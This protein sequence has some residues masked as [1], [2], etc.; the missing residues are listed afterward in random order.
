MGAVLAGGRSRRMGRDKATVV[1][2]GVT[3]RERAIAALMTV[4]DR[5]VVV[6]GPGAEIVDGGDGPLVALVALLR[7]HPGQYLVVSATDQPQLTAAVLAPLLAAVTDTVDGDDVVAWQGQPLPMALGLGVL[8]RLQQLV[9]GGERRLRCAVT[10]WLPIVDADVEAGLIDVDT[11]EDLA[12][13]V[14][15]RRAPP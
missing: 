12:A 4:C 14:D 2:D 9:D 15:S 7:A 5:V 3:M 8:P 11:P 10:T 1:I 6:G 13:L